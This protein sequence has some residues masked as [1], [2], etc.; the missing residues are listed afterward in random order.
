[1]KLKDHIK[2]GKFLLNSTDHKLSFRQRA[3]FLFGC[4]GP[5]INPISR[6]RGTSSE[7]YF[8][9]HNAEYIREYIDRFI[10]KIDSNEKFSVYN[11]LTLGNIIHYLADSFTF[12]HN[13]HFKGC[14]KEHRRYENILHDKFKDTLSQYNNLKNFN[15]ITPIITFFHKK[16][17][18]YKSLPQSIETD[19]EYIIKVCGAAFQNLMI[20]PDYNLVRQHFPV[21][22]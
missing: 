1:M 12:A 7:D 11:Y 4:I 14:L 15:L 3:A 13:D 6:V 17:D 2:L 5:D 16:H 18:Q 20:E 21:L 10:N 8:H 9:G 19:I 22:D